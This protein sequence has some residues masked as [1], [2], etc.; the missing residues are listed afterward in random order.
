MLK[1]RRMLFQLPITTA[2]NLYADRKNT[3][4]YEHF[5]TT[6]YHKKSSR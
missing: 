5:E 6:K 2:I 4:K 1:A 3:G